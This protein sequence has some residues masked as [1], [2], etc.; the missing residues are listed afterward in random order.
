MNDPS[1]QEL[2]R[3]FGLDDEEIEE[4]TDEFAD[5]PGLDMELV[6]AIGYRILFDLYSCSNSTLKSSEGLEGFIETYFH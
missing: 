4:F 3:E 6:S 1:Y 2:A 5:A